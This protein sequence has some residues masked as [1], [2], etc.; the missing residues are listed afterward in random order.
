MAFLRLF[1][2]GDEI[3][4]L[5]HLTYFVSIVD[6]L[7]FTAAARSLYVSQPTLSHGI[8]ILETELNTKLFVR[9]H[10]SLI[11]TPA[12]K[13]LYELAV[14]ILDLTN[15]IYEEVPPKELSDEKFIRVGFMADLLQPCFVSF[16]SPFLQ[17]HPEV[18]FHLEQKNVSGLHN[19]LVTGELDAIFTRSSSLEDMP[20]V[21][22]E[23]ITIQKDEFCLV[24]PSGHPAAKYSRLDDLSILKDD[25]FIAMDP[26]H[27]LPLTDKL[28][29]IC[30][31]RNYEPH[32][33]ET[34][35]ML[36]ATLVSVAS[37]NGIT[38]TPRSYIQQKNYPNVTMIELSGEDIKN[39]IVVCRR[40][41]NINPV[42]EMFISYLEYQAA[43]KMKQ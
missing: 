6:H 14:Q 4:N 29:R 23:S 1:L 7:S 30:R 21:D 17:S 20:V 31:K 18:H 5:N 36:D 35:A 32:I 26:S 42:L 27:T 38:I 40:M 24:V 12:G 9:N 43:D 15:R 34:A 13:R 3:V 10:H 19:Q 25:V 41:D 11:P 37:G 8:R 22:S 39:D 28:I 2:T 16:V 33:E